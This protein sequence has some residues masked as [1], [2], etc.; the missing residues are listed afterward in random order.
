MESIEQEYK[1]L[2]IER[3]MEETAKGEKIIN[4]FRIYY[5]IF[6]YMVV[7]SWLW[8]FFLSNGEVICQ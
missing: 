4:R 6:L 3:V 8:V 1:R 2:R 7:G 5:L